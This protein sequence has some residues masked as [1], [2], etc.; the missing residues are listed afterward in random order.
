MSVWDEGS[1]GCRDSAVPDP[2]VRLMG[3]RSA[4]RPVGVNV[5]PAGREDPASVLRAG[6]AAVDGPCVVL[7]GGARGVDAE[8]IE[9]FAAALKAGAACASQRLE[10]R[11]G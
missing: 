6:L 11:T 9:R 5:V 2:V 10:L 1:L 4:S 7:L 3:H 8:R